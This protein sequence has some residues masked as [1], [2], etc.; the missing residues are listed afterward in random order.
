MF[1]CSATLTKPELVLIT[2]SQ[3]PALSILLLEGSGATLPGHVSL[4]GIA[5]REN[6]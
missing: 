2:L 1:H 4:L 5:Q 6:D 3:L